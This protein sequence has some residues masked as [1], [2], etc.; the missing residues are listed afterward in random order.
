MR[1]HF[2][3]Q[4]E[5]IMEREVIDLKDSDDEAVDADAPLVNVAAV[6]MITVVVMGPTQL[7]ARPVF[8]NWLRG[9][10]MHRCVTNKKTPKTA[11]F[12]EAFIEK[13]QAMNMTP[14]HMGYPLFPQGPVALEVQFHRRLPNTTFRGSNRSRPFAG[15]QYEEGMMY[16]DTMRPDVDNLLKFVMDALNGVI[17]K[18]DEQAVKTVAPKLLDRERPCEGCTIVKFKAADHLVDVPL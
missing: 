8:M 11:A 13:L 1:S 18:D 7:M 3:V 16:Y 4:N 15:R 17:H 14:T 6:N 2:L 5:V 10:Q 12:R 9:N